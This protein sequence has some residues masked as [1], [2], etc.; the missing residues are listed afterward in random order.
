MVRPSTPAPKASA[1][2]AARGQAIIEVV[3]AIPRGEVRSYAEVARAAGWPRHA[4]LVAKLLS[5]AETP[6]PWHRVLRADG[7]IA[8][9][10]GSAAWQEQ[11]Q[12]LRAEGVLLVD[13]RVRRGADRNG[14]ERSLDAAVWGGG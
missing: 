1:L 8:F 7:R 5:E 4:R 12:R 11:A 3:R 10:A 6:L 9:P 14:A 2:S 13:G